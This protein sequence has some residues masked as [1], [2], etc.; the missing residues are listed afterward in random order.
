MLSKIYYTTT[1]HINIGF[2]LARL[3][4]FVKIIK[5]SDKK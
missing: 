5:D 2:I 4:H 1:K 3:N